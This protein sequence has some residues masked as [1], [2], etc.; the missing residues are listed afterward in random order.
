MEQKIA[1]RIGRAIRENVFPGCV[2]GWVD[3]RRNHSVLPFG[4]FE[5]APDSRP[6]AEDSIFDVASITKSIPTSS[7]ALQLMDAGKLKLEDKVLDY[8]SGIAFS[9]REKVLVRHLLTHTLNYGFRL[10][11]L[12]DLGPSG[13][14]HAILSTELVSEPGSTFFYSNATSIL[15]GM[16]IEKMWGECLAV[17]ARRELFDPLAMKRTSFF[18]EE[19]PRDEIVPTEID[20]W[21]GRTILAEVHD[22]SAWTLRQIM[23]AGSAGLFSTVPDLLKFL[24]MLLDRGTHQGTRY[25]S[26]NC[27]SLMSTNQ[28]GH[29]GLQTGLGWELGQ[30][31]Y[32]GKA[33]SSSTI[34]KTGFTGCVCMC[35]FAGGTALALLSNS[36][37]P[38][39]KPDTKALD[40]VRRDI[41]DIVFSTLNA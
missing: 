25:F 21:R 24:S 31:R 10:S 37:F 27:L 12:K 28:T 35:D 5:Y 34:G 22:E 41:A 3:K 2:V 30:A 17:T 33:C 19:F 16:V 4:R 13:I 23:I 6:M 1:A 20:Q 15:L 26:E 38:S 36:T 39:R 29:L 11:A 14:L 7:L 9:H 32:M 8:V 18:P 40:E